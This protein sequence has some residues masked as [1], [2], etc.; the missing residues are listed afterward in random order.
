MNLSSVALLDYLIIVILAF[1]NIAF[2]FNLNLSSA[3]SSVS[4]ENSISSNHED[5]LLY[6]Y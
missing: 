3:K 6:I 2:H 4:N 5:T 1:Y